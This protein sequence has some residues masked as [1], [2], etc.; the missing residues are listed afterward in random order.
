MLA[1]RER[2]VA[3]M[4][5]RSS[6][7]DTAPQARR[8]LAAA[9]DPELVRKCVAEF[10]GTAALVFFGAGVST[11]SFGFRAYGTSV[12]AGV[13]ATALAFA[14]VL[15]ALVAIMAPIS[16]G[17]VNPAVTLGAY[18]TRRIP[19][20]DALGYWVAQLLGGILGALLLLW[21][22]H[23]SPFYIKSRI[24][25][26]ANGWGRLS[27]LHISGGGAFLT[28]VI[29]TAVFVAIVL[30]A[31]HMEAPRP[32]APLV[33]GLSLGLVNLVAVP[34]DGA[35]ANPARSFGPALVTAGLALS[36]V[37]LFILAPLVGAVLAA[38][39][40]LL[41]YPLPPG[42]GSLFG[43][44]LAQPAASSS[45]ADEGSASSDSPGGERTTS[46]GTDPGVTPGTGTPRPADGAGQ[47]GE[48]GGGSSKPDRP[49]PGS[50]KN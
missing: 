25:L 14:I 38:G 39:L 24:G 21:V 23:S 49:Q 50:D 33:I 28:E 12:A 44:R 7:G 5:D 8:T 47:G 36:Q 2:E 20:K 17:H 43:N 27:L 42:S 30:S 18:L 48:S 31:T 46:A 15:T 40:H 45:A 3:G 34:I 16:G 9:A 10:L 32:L 37:W 11:V 1:W 26:G 19:F 22:M 29:I 13:V 4:A 41:F 6:A 35:S